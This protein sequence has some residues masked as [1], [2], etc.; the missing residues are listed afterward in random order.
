[1]N[2]LF[3]LK[4]AIII[5]LLSILLLIS[6]NISASHSYADADDDVEHSGVSYEEIIKNYENIGCS[7]DDSITINEIPL[8]QANKIVTLP[9]S[10]MYTFKVDKAYSIKQKIG[11]N[12]EEETVY[13][14]VLITPKTAV[15]SSV[16]ETKT[17]RVNISCTLGYERLTRNNISYVKGTYV[18]GKVISQQN[19]I[20]VTS[21]SAV[22]HEVGAY[23]TS[24][25]GSG[26]APDY[27]KTFALDVAKKN[28]FQKK[29]LS[30]T[31][32]FDT[33]AT[34][35]AVDGKFVA[36][37]KA[38]GYNTVYTIYVNASAS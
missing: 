35:G 7:V 6:I 19:G 4:N 2:R 31:R 21:L 10:N 24:S 16:T 25:G 26:I 15:L 14:D 11:D 20:Q 13:A 1:M 28:S 38:N 9:K 36:K 18:G 12:M 5:V 37:Y 27:K 3:L 30:R 22:Y 29:T 23:I 8:E 33:N 17:G 32:Y 34:V